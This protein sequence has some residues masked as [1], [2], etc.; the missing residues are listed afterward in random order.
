LGQ[1]EAANESWTLEMLFGKGGRAWGRTFSANTDQP[2]LEIVADELNGLGAVFN[3][4]NA[5]G[6]FLLEGTDGLLG[7]QLQ[8]LEEPDAISD[9]VRQCGDGRN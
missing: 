4:L 1:K 9:V 7:D 3:L 5:V 6:G 8:K 2:N